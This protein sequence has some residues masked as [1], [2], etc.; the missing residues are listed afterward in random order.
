MISDNQRRKNS[1][2]MDVRNHENVGTS[3]GGQASRMINPSNLPR[4][5]SP[6]FIPDD[7]PYEALSTETTSNQHKLH[8]AYR[9]KQPTGKR[10][11]GTRHS[12]GTPL[13]LP[14]DSPEKGLSVNAASHQKSNVADQTGKTKES[15]RTVAR[16]T[17][18]TPFM[19]GIT[20]DN[21][22]TGFTI[23]PPQSTRIIASRTPPGGRSLPEPSANSLRSPSPL[24]S[25]QEAVLPSSS[26]AGPSSITTLDKG[27]TPM[28]RAPRKS[29]RRPR[30]TAPGTIYT[31]LML[32]IIYPY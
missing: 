29:A 20:L 27:K 14:S 25:M 10:T 11:G 22:D 5:S 6:L 13:F 15:A 18:S 30:P 17:Q 31:H 26:E 7:D 16:R 23:T 9:M 21:D 1:A 24:L 12:A 2:H 3:T 28:S 19:Q 4:S 8:G 32:K